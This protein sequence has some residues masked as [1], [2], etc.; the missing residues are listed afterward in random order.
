[1]QN[2]MG[3]PSGEGDGKVSF[4]HLSWFS[5]CVLSVLTALAAGIVRSGGML[6]TLA[7]PAV[8]ILQYYSSLM[9]SFSVELPAGG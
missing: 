3:R 1:M 4:A 7:I 2:D 6:M 9:M 5:S 8:R